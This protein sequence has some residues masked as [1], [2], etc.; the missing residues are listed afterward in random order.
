MPFKI[1]LSS[2]VVSMLISIN[3]YSVKL[4]VAS[5]EWIKWFEWLCIH[6][7]CMS[8]SL[9]GHLLKCSV[10]TC[11]VHCANKF[12][13]PISQ[14]CSQMN[15]V[16][17]DYFGLQFGTR[18]GERHW[19]NL[20]NSITAQLPIGFSQPIRLDLRVKFHVEPH[21]LQQ[22]ITRWVIVRV[23]LISNVT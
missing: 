18:K 1:N 11:D 23:V 4:K 9:K 19:L 14:A 13:S 12:T 3:Y 20:R 15:L 7:I 2:S 10:S 21:I 22:D 16:E 5:L 6:V 8:R 17:G